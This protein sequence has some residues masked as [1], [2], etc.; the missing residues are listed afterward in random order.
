MS[1]TLQPVTRQK[2]APRWCIGCQRFH[3]DS[4][5][6]AYSSESCIEWQ[7]KEDARIQHLMTIC[8]RCHSCGRWTAK[9]GPAH[10][11]AC[12]EKRTAQRVTWRENAKKKREAIK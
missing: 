3:D 8:K 4:A 1:E 6:R 11:A 9:N 7:A 12:R 5:F 10:C 2:S